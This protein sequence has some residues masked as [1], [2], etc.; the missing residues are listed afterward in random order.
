MQYGRLQSVY[1]C[2][3]SAMVLR[4]FTMPE[5][6]TDL[7]KKLNVFVSYSRRDLEFADQLVAVLAWQR[8]QP[9]ID[10]EGIHAAENWE[11]RLGQL[12]LEADIVVFVLSPDSAASKVCAWEVDEAIRR[13]KR[14]IPVLCRS[15]DG[16]LPHSKLRELNYIHFYV[17]KDV[18]GSGFGTGQVRLIEALSIDVE[19]LREHTRLEEL[20]ARWD[21]NSRDPD[22]LVRGSELTTFNS[23]RD[24]RPSNAPNLTMIQRA[25]LAASDEEESARTNAQR[26]QLA[27]MASVQSQRQIAI[28]EREAAIKREADAQQAS[29]K[30]RRIITWGAIAGATLIVIAALAFATQQNRN[31]QEQAKLRIEAE[32]NTALAL[33]QKS[34]VDELIRRIRVGRT[35]PPGISAMKNICNEAI[36]VT[37]RLASTTN[38][39]EFIQNDERFWELYYGSMNLVEIRQRTDNYSGDSDDIVMSSIES[40]MVRFGDKLKYPLESENDLPRKEL[41]QLSMK[42]KEECEE[43]LT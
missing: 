32:K 38:E 41:E 28:E 27:E 31:Y 24:R 8:F 42:V 17:D 36:T 12:I 26:K 4:V 43:Y 2:L 37:S 11:Q 9:I 6:E 5:T 30:A 14:I 21:D 16:Q 29:A 39:E 1:A 3:Y 34:V 7:N 19:W 40:A 35:N 23:W 10:R 13:G 20:A 15:L 33:A 18:P 25:F 22:L